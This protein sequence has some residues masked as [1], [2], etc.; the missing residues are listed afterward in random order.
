MSLKCP[1]CQSENPDDARFCSQCTS[2]LR[3][4][5][6]ASKPLTKT[7]QIPKDELQ[8]GMTFANRYQI[9]EKL[10][11]GGMGSVYKVLDSEIDEEVALKLLNPD[12]TADEN[13]IQRFRNELKIARMILHRNVCRMFDISQDEGSYYITRERTTQVDDQREIYQAMYARLSRVFS[14]AFRLA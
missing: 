9:V 5:E 3:P 6:T 1:E 7:L 10:G 8:A 2:P 13:T 14:D 4:G 11:R 12:I